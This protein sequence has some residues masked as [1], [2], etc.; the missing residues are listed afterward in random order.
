MLITGIFHK[1]NDLIS[2]ICLTTRW[3]I[4]TQNGRKPLH[5]AEIVGHMSQN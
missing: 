1:I 3:H 4:W 2:S 5:L